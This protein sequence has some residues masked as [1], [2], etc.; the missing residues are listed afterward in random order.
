MSNDVKFFETP[1]I[2]KN[3][4]QI[5]KLQNNDTFFA[6]ILNTQKKFE[7]YLQLNIHHNQKE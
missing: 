1:C 7:K 6:L 4:A 2:I 5:N 3:F